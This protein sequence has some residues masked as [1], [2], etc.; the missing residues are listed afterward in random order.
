MLSLWLFDDAWLKLP[1]DK[2]LTMLHNKFVVEEPCN[3][4]VA[5]KGICSCFSLV[6]HFEDGMMTLTN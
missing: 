3:K 4:V 2:Q 5:M 6:I 1:T